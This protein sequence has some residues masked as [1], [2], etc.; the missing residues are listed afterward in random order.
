M[1]GRSDF[2]GW[3][4]PVTFAVLATVAYVYLVP[5]QDPRSAATLEPSTST[6][7]QHETTSPPPLPGS[8]ST[9]LQTPAL[10]KWTDAQGRTH[11][12]DQAPEG[13]TAEPLDPAIGER[14]VIRLS[15]LAVAPD[16]NADTT[17]NVTPTPEPARYWTSP[18]ETY[19]C[20]T[21]KEHIERIDEVMRAGYTVRQGE[22]LKANRRALTKLRREYC[23]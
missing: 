2:F 11:Y 6:S 1:H 12:G 4:L 18:R 20:D 7:T 10:Y 23:F 3:F 13:V 19:S 22:R 5:S 21:I 17:V 14:N 8:A 15:P 16:S 9:P